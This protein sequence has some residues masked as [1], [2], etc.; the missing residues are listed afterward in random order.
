MRMPTPCPTIV[1]RG[2]DE[3]CSGDSK[4]SITVGPRLG[5]SHGRCA[6]RPT[7]PVA[8]STTITRIA[9]YSAAPRRPSRSFARSRMLSP[10]SLRHD[11]RLRRGLLEPG[12]Q[13]GELHLRLA[14]APVDDPAQLG[15]ADA[16]RRLLHRRPGDVDEACEQVEVLQVAQQPERA[17]AGG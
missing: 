13:P 1:L 2:R 9:A 14:L 17:G 10:M 7:T 4:N 12:R 8:A 11:Q 16:E 3:G 5:N 15:V 6:S